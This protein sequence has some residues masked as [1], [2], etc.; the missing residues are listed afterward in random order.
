MSSPRLG[1]RHALLVL[2][3]VTLFGA[4]PAKPGIRVGFADRDITPDIGMEVPE[5]DP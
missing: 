2:A 1:L 3:T 4:P 5:E